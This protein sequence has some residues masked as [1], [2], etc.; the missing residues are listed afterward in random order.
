MIGFIVWTHKFV[1]FGNKTNDVMTK[2]KKNNQKKKTW[3]LNY[4]IVFPI[5]HHI[6]FHNY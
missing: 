1:E 3:K 4:F 5:G 6:I 2:Q